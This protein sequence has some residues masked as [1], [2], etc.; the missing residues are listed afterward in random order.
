VK[1]TE[2][3]LRR[4]IG[5]LII[6]GI[7]VLIGLLSLSKLK[8]DLYPD[9]ELPIIAVITNYP[10]A[11]PEEVEAIVSKPLESTI[12]TVPNVTKVSSTSY[13][14]VSVVMAES[15]YGADLD[16]ISLSMRERIDMVKSNLPKDVSAPIVF[17]FDPA[18]MPIMMLGVGGGSDL[19]AATRLMDNTIVPRL[20]RIPGVAS[21]STD[22]GLVREF[23]VEVDQIRLLSY[24]LTLAQ[25]E[26][27]LRSENLN[28]PGGT[29]NQGRT[30]YLIRSLGQFKSVEDLKSLR[31][32]LPRG[33]TVALNEVAAI[34]DDYQEQAKLTR[35]NGQ[36][37][38]ALYIQK[39]SDANTVLTARKIRKELAAIQKEMG[40]RFTY[41]MVFDQAES[42]EQNLRTVNSNAI[43]G[44][45]LAIIILWLF[46][47]N[48]GTTMVI[49]LS[50]PISIVVTFA[51]MYFRKMTLNMISL[52]GLALGVGML[53]DNSIV[54]LENIYRYRQEGVDL[55][56]AAREG[57]NEVGMAILGS[58]T[59]SIV[60]FLPVFF[61]EGLAGQIF[62]D[63]AL[64]VGFSL[65][66][67]LAVALTIVPIL[68]RR[69]LHIQGERSDG[70]HVFGRFGLV[71]ERIFDPVTNALGKLDQI[72]RRMLGYAVRHR[73]RIIITGIAAF[74][75]GFLPFFLGL[76]M[77]FMSQGAS[78]G[79]SIGL[80]LPSG[81]VLQETDRVCRD[82]EEYLSALPEV[83][84]ITTVAGSGST[85]SMF[86]S[87]RT[88]DRGS[89]SVT[90]KS[91]YRLRMEKVMED[92]RGFA[93]RFPDVKT[94]V[95]ATQAMGGPMSGAPIQVEVIGPDLRV[96]ADL[97]KQ[98]K[99]IVAS[100]SGTREVKTS[101]EEG[102]PEVQ[103][104]INREK[105]AMLG[106]SAA[107]VAS[108]LRTAYQGS[109]PTRL[110][111]GGDEYD[112][113][114]ILS[115][116]DRERLQDLRHLAL[117][118][119]SGGRVSLGDVA[120][121]EVKAGPTSVQ[122]K[123][124]TRVVI[125][126]AS[127]YG[128]DLG[129][130]SAEVSRRLK[131]ISVPDQYKVGLGG[132]AFDMT[133]SFQDL[134]WAMLY[135][136]LLVY[137]V[138]AIQYETL[139]NPLMILFTIPLMGFGV[140]W[141]LFATGRPLNVSGITGAIMLT[142]IVVN[143]AIVLIDYVETLRHRGMS[144]LDAVLKAGPTRLRPVLMTTLTTILGVLPLALGFGEGGEFEAPLATVV[145]GGLACSTLLTLLVI[146][147]VYLAVHETMDR[148]R[149]LF[150]PGRVTA[151]RA[152]D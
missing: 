145:A 27:V 115:G 150:A 5:T 69:F 93:T 2:L 19:E 126:S 22:G 14:G 112:I 46:L 72:Y 129:S 78:T 36:A 74:I 67:S 127:L 35:I 34:R 90:L 60:V 75:L 94:E 118:S 100:V 6:F 108:T 64:T 25:I 95:S 73:R 83:E 85:M 125:V 139:L 122:R 30:E 61:V 136:I 79:F 58:T 143:N 140:T 4:P 134:A 113:R 81:R 107:Q 40:D 106:I 148:V 109:V 68:S 9:I 119:P 70:G 24:G 23:R 47:R 16:M 149:Q 59:T 104:Q 66:A 15:N 20:K 52:G 13:A 128:R 63:M 92:V 33:G 116:K 44:A 89:I 56:T 48:I 144:R 39:E 147:V 49:G 151:A 28:Y 38:L 135:A 121:I 53:V 7:F 137:M 132:Q 130:T 98:V 21:V 82:F 43:M 102:A 87:Q 105:A 124:Q 88:T 117:V 37:G 133:E 18:M 84:S 65:L 29:T 91:Q 146:P 120:T 41:V 31:L 114:V 42:I 1:I 86:G 11:G 138:L 141:S 45:L 57:T 17:K 99:E 32:T 55:T 50:I 111:L 103:L 54:V 101:L 152:T 62:R 76:K 8:M 80:R 97:S 96:L 71:F 10:G 110:R 12:E 3:S 77:D 123:E 26:G 51:L 142:G 131:E